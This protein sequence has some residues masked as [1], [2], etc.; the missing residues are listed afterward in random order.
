MI[1]NV[2]GLLQGPAAPAALRARTC[3]VSEANWG[4]AVLLV[5]E[6]PVMPVTLSSVVLP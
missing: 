2:R 3:Q 6:R 1:V 4:S 5:H